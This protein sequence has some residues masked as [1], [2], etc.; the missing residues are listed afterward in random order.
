MEIA[1]KSEFE[2]Q[3]NYL[4]IN[5]MTHIVG[6]VAGLVCSASRRIELDPFLHHLVQIR[7]IAGSSSV[8]MGPSQRVN[9]ISPRPG[10]RCLTLLP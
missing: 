10:G 4:Y 9:E 8:S 2:P 6:G 7:N 3:V 5:M 1:A